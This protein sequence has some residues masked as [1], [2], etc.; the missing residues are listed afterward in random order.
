ML[1][2]NMLVETLGGSL[3]VNLS[4]NG[5]TLTDSKDRVSNIIATD[6]QA[7]NG[8]IHAIDKVVLE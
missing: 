2:N 8:V 7:N 5:A 4:A 3:T 1:S 6:V